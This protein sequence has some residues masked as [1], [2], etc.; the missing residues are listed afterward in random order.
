MHLEIVRLYATVF[1]ENPASARVLEK[2]GY[3]LEGTARQAIVK[4][5]RILDMFLYAKLKD[6]PA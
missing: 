6:D 1:A 5:D 2:C 3:T 4:N